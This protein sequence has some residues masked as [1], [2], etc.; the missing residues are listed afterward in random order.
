MQHTLPLFVLYVRRPWRR[1]GSSHVARL[2]YRHLAEVNLQEKPLEKDPKVEAQQNPGRHWV[3]AHQR[4]SS[5]GLDWVLCI[6]PDAR[7][8]LSPDRVRGARATPESVHLLETF[9][10]NERSCRAPDCGEEGGPG[11]GRRGEGGEAASLP[12]THSARTWRTVFNHARPPMRELLLRWTDLS[13]SMCRRR[14]KVGRN[15]RLH[16]TTISLEKAIV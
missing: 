7:A 13:A 15:L 3:A 8:R 2:C 10:E 12:D 11:P 6:A 4:A 14:S 16:I 1:R 5:L 9:H